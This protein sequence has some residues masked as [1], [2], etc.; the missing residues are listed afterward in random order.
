MATKTAKMFETRNDLDVETR[1]KVIALLNA[2]LADDRPL[3]YCKNGGYNGES[4]GES[5]QKARGRGARGARTDASHD[6]ALRHEA[7]DD[8]TRAAG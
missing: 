2:R 1:E 8:I 5:H 3:R 7:D 6:G 4:N